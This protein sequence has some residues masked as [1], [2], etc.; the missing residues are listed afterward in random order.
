MVVVL[1]FVFVF[2][3][4]PYAVLSLIGIL[5]FSSRIPLISTVIPNMMAKEGY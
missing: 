2:C 4:T 5:G 3:W 1:V